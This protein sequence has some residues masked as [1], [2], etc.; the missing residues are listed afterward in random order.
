MKTDTLLATIGAI[1]LMSIGA[2]SA[3][4]R[5]F[6]ARTFHERPQTRM[7][8]PHNVSVEDVERVARRDFLAAQLS[9]VAT[10]LRG[11]DNQ[12]EIVRT[13]VRLGALKLADG[14][15]EALQKYIAAAN[16]DYWDVVSWAEYC[17]NR[18]VSMDLNRSPKKLSTEVQKQTPNVLWQ[19]YEDWLRR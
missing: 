13:R 19:Q 3:L 6:Y 1:A 12:S 9:E 11:F 17:L 15:L 10:V 8:N 16:Q 18:K 4:K 14:N 7:G 5:R 2:W